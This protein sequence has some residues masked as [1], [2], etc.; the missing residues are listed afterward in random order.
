MNMT[1]QKSPIFGFAVTSTWDQL[2][3]VPVVSTFTSV[4]RFAKGVLCG[5]RDVV[6]WNK[7]SLIQD[8]RDIGRAICEVI[9]VVNMIAAYYFNR[10]DNTSKLVKPDLD[11]LIQ[12][13]KGCEKLIVELEISE[14]TEKTLVALKANY[15]KLTGV[16]WDDL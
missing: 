9:P 6:L 5:L 3:E 4:A 8:A 13:I 16:D 2:G 7:D 12:D 11:S 15:Q 10:S 14:N 1:I